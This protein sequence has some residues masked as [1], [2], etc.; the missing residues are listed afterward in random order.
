M[1]L[2][3]TLIFVIWLPNQKPQEARMVMP[4]L[5]KCITAAQDVGSDFTSDPVRL[6]NGAQVFVGCELV[7]APHQDSRATPKND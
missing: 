7:P 6:P 3:V 1:N 2:I 5:A 4:S